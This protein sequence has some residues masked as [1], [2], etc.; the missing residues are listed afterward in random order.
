M[1]MAMAWIDYKKVYDMVSHS[2]IKERMKIYGIANN[3]RSF[4]ENSMETWRMELTSYGETLDKTRDFS[5]RQF[6]TTAICFEYDS[7]DSGSEKNRNR[8]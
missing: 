1:N 4:L 8:L 7:S 3:I 6:V 5:R 2:W